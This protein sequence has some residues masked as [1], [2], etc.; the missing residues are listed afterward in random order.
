[1]SSPS[2]EFGATTISGSTRP[3]DATAA[4]G[5][6]TAAVAAEIRAVSVLP[7]GTRGGL[8]VAMLGSGG[9]VLVERGDDPAAPIAGEHEWR[10]LMRA[11][12]DAGGK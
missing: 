2:S 9:A 6:P 11:A 12:R 3:A 1:M 8:L 5:M 4:S 10:T 7:D